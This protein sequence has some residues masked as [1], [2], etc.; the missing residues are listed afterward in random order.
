MK[1]QLLQKD[2]SAGEK[3]ILQHIV[4]LKYI[5]KKLIHVA[6]GLFSSLYRRRYQL[7]LL[8]WIGAQNLQIYSQQ[9][10][11]HNSHTNSAKL[12]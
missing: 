9:F 5:V 12:R 11:E 8:F 4:Q 1:K 6:L 10:L 3:P 7:R 2:Q